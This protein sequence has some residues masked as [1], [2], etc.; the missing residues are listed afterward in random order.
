LASWLTRRLPGA[1]VV[2]SPWRRAPAEAADLIVN[3]TSVGM[4][5]SDPPPVEPRR[6]RPGTLVYDLVYHRT[7]ALVR[8]TRR[9]GCIAADG[10]SMLL[11]QGAES[12]RLWL[13]VR[14]PVAPMRRALEGLLPRG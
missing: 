4:R 2:V 1:D 6:V 8:E 14:P 5:P 12:L 11:Y 10:R 9:R 13:G 7:T 3:A